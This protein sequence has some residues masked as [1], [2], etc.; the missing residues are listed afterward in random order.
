MKPNSFFSALRD[1]SCPCR[2][3]LNRR[4]ILH[5]LSCWGSEA[6]REGGTKGPRVP[7]SGEPLGKV[8]KKAIKHTWTCSEMGGV[9]FFFYCCPRAP[10]CIGTALQRNH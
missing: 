8:E 4:R 3:E 1:R 10:K 6:G 2:R 9:H 7:G 5:D